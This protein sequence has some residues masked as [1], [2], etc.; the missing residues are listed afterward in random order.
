MKTMAEHAP[1]PIVSGKVEDFFLHVIEPPAGHEYV[2][3]DGR[4]LHPT[5][6]TDQFRML[7]KDSKGV[8]KPH[9]IQGEFVRKLSRAIE[10]TQNSLEETCEELVQ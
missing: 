9:F 7:L 8:I 2:T 4:L 5:Y 10:A 3:H 6:G 1:I